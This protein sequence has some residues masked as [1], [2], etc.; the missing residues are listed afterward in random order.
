MVDQVVVSKV[1]VEG[2][3]LEGQAERVERS[4]IDVVDRPPR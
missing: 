2:V 3:V 4:M 1:V